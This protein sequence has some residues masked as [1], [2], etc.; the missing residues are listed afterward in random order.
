MRNLQKFDLAALADIDGGRIALAF[1][2][3][4]RRCAQDCDDRPGEKKPRTLTLQLSVKP[5]IDQDG[6]CEDCDVVVT[7]ADNV[8]KR[9]SKSYNCSL[10]K[11]GHLA[12]HPDSL[13]DHEQETFDFSEE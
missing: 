10:R 1:E 11:G 7:V 6:M 13:D 5:V 9:K 12:Y 8:P 4:L 2:Q 3:A